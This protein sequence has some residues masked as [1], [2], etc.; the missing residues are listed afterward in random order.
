MTHQRYVLIVIPRNNFIFWE[1]KNRLVCFYLSPFPQDNI[2]LKCCKI[3][4]YWSH[5]VLS[6]SMKFWC[7]SKISI[8]ICYLHWHLTL[9]CNA[10]QY[11]DRVKPEALLIL[12]IWTHTVVLGFI[13]L[14]STI[15]ISI[16][17]N[18]AN[19]QVQIILSHQY[20]TNIWDTMGMA[21]TLSDQPPTFLN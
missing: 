5:I 11:I 21:L 13:I 6:W 20:C 10:N 17:E 3:L 4:A 18:Y 8:K 9:N 12:K 16:A 14:P 7:L 15:K 19:A 1:D 2:E